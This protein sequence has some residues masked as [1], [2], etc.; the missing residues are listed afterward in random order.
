[1][2]K[3]LLLAVLLMT[4]AILL[5]NVLF[6]PPARPP[7]EE[8]QVTDSAAA[9]A[10]VTGP[11]AVPTALPPEAQLGPADSVIVESA[12]YRFVFS[13]RGAALHHAELLTYPSYTAPGKPV[14][15]VPPG[16]EDFLS[17][18]LLVGN[19]TIDLR[20]LL[21][22]PSVQNLHVGEGAGDRSVD[23]TYADSLGFGI[24]LR[25]TFEPA[26]YLFTVSG[27]IDGLGGQQARLLTDIGPGFD[28]HEH[29]DHHNPSVYAV[30]TRV[31]GAVDRE[32]FRNIEGTEVSP[33]PLTWAGIK[34][35]YFVATIIGG[36]QAPLDGISKTSLPADER[37]ID[38]KQLV[39][40]RVLLT[41]AVPVA[42][43]GT[44][45]FQSYLGPQEYDR[46]R[47]IGYDLEEV[48]PYGYRWLQPVI[49]PLAAAVLWVLNTLHDTLGLAYGWV[50]VLF[51]VMMRVVLWPLNAKAMR[52]QMKN[53]AV[54]PLIQEIRDKYKNEPEKQQQAMLALHKEHGFNPF[55]GCLPMLVPFPVL[56]T[57]FFV[58]QNTIAFRGARFLWL[59]DLSLHDPLYI[60]PVILVV[61][62]FALQWVMS[63]LSGIEQ[64]PQM[65]AMMYFMPIMLGAIFFRLPGGLNLYYAVTQL[66]SIPQQVLIAKER[67]KAQEEM[68]TT[69]SPNK[70]LAPTPAPRSRSRPKR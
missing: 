6:P 10:V 69:R 32:L 52:A 59:P 37:E 15:L 36:E 29:P 3:R 66:A 49:R 55:A 17:Q 70:V 18:R 53:M 16:V 40:P 7:A 2:E 33:T 27:R 63:H 4:A 42:P 46:L 19:D 26:N 38:G 8:T 58:F 61:S 25:Y 35:K 5:T 11:A 28:V 47:G 9:P 1:M 67:R 64:N 30:V 65:K 60:L 23:F 57:L 22:A 50:L 34:N 54:Q 24:A 12:L 20:R 13:T 44:F 39:L 43:D 21:Y 62:M 14:Q 41:A 45:S 48:T 51:G 68:K 56:V 31:P